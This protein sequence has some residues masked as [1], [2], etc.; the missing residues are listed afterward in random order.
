MTTTDAG[1]FT[2]PA[3]VPS[4]GYSITVSKQG[5]NNYEVKDFEITVGQTVDF[6]ISLS[7][8]TTTTKVDITAE[9][10][11]VEDTKSGV[12][13]TV[14]QQQILDLTV[15]ITKTPAERASA[16]RFRRMRYRS[17]RY[18]PMASPPNSAAPWA[19]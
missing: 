11:M 16:A 7:I 6:K 5:F 13:S 4:S 17:S 8:G 1:L 14:G 3:L 12:T 9:A 2:A 15:F 10:P 19:A 18:S